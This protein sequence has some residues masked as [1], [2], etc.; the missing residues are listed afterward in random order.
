MKITDYEISRYRLPAG[1]KERLEFDNDQPGFGVH[2]RRS[3]THSFFL[4]YGAG[5]NRKRPAIG[6]VGEIRAADARVVAQEWMAASRSGKD[7]QAEK[8]RARVRSSETFGQLL[9]KFLRRQL[10][11]WKPR[12]LKEATYSLNA[13]TKPFRPLPI[14]TIDKRMVAARLEEIETESGPGARNGARSYLSAFFGWAVDEGLC[15]ENPAENTSKVTIAPRQR[16]LLDFEVKAILAALDEPARADDDYCDIL[17]LALHL[18]LRRAEAGSLK[19]DE[20][21][22]DEAALIFPPGRTKNSQAW[23]VPLSA[24]A[25]ELLKARA[26]KLDRENS[27]T[28]VFGRGDRTGFAGWSKGKKELDARIVALNAGQPLEPWVLHDFRRLLVTTLTERMGVQPF[29]ADLL[30]GHARSGLQA[31]YNLAEHVAERRRVLERWASHLETIATGV[32]PDTRFVNLDGR[33][34]QT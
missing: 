8:A 14:S 3:G 26:A 12:T 9:P 4:Q 27:R 20:V 11:E 33:R 7:P 15:D 5:K 34:R 1:A 17:K 13:H 2:F 16:K 31:V 23:T 24:P 29:L 21:R 28:F 6:R 22:F 18:G 10:T 30:L 19:W 32:E 25:L